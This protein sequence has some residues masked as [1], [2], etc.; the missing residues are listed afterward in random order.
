[1][2]IGRCNGKIKMIFGLIRLV[3]FVIKW[4]QIVE[5]IVDIYIIYNV[6]YCCV[7]IRLNVANVGKILEK[8]YINLCVDNV[9]INKGNLDLHKLSSL[10]K[11]VGKMRKKSAK[12]AE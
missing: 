11:K 8:K 5:H 3:E 2:Y 7:R 1:M 10:G 12:L 9:K 6:L 4:G